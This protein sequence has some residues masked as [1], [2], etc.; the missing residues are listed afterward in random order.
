MNFNAYILDWSMDRDIELRQEL[1][2]AN[3]MFEKKGQSEHIHVAVSFERVNEF[4][5]LCQAHL[6]SPFNYVDI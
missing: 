2:K 1:A 5:S 3:F 4:A 6:N